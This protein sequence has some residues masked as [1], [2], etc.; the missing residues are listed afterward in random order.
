M[1]IEDYNNLKD[2][3]LS[4]L[5]QDGD[6]R[7]FSVIILRYKDSLINHIKSFSINTED[8]ED[9]FQ[10]CAKKAYLA[11]NSYDNKYKFTTWIYNIAKNSAIDYQRKQTLTIIRDEEGEIIYNYPDSVYTPEE[12]MVFNQDYEKIVSNI[13]KLKPPYN[14]IADLRFIQELAYEEIAATLNIP[15]NTIRTRVKKAKELLTELIKEDEY[16]NNL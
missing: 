9:L 15:L 6:K 2:N 16:R 7:A 12:R 1:I 8:A 13:Q 4:R 3:E 10:E 5:A 14:T 11:I